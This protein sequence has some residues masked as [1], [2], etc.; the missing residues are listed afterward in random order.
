VVLTTSTR[1]TKTPDFIEVGTDIWHN[2]YDCHI[3]YG[4][5]ATIG[6]DTVGRPTIMVMT[7]TVIMRADLGVNYVGLPYDKA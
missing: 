5:P 6:R 2:I 7:T 1:N 3:R 4:Q